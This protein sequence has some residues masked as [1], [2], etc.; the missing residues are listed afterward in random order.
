MELITSE[1]RVVELTEKVGSS[2]NLH[3]VRAIC[4]DLRELFCKIDIASKEQI[5]KYFEGEYDDQIVSFCL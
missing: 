3:E 1:G 4:D 2:S 5:W